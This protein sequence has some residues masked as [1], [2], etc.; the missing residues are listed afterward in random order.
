[1]KEVKNIKKEYE[2]IMTMFENK[3]EFPKEFGDLLGDISLFN[4]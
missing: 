4:I 2:K 3:E 1:M